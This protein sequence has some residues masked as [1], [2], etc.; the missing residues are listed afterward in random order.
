MWRRKGKNSNK[1]QKTKLG[2]ELRF[3]AL[4]QMYRNLV[5][6]V[7]KLHACMGK[8]RTLAYPH[9]IRVMVKAKYED[10]TF[11]ADIGGFNIIQT[12]V[13]RGWV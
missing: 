6:R 12:T 3:L 11:V 13:N 5:S 8:G 7:N 4:K 10:R 2:D 1:N 9:K